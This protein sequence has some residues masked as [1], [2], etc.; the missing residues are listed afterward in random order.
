MKH[1]EHIIFHADTR[2][3]GIKRAAIT[4]NLDDFSG[5]NPS[6]PLK[7]DGQPTEIRFL[8]DGTPILHYSCPVCPGCLSC[9]VSGKGMCVREVQGNAARIQKYICNDR[10]YP[11][12][13]S[14]PGYGYGKR[15]SD[16]VIEKTAKSSR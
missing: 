2:I 4:T 6:S 5:D 10:S 11:F 8:R 3:P 1:D 12:E 15:I 14:H 16:D 13:A 7:F 9:R